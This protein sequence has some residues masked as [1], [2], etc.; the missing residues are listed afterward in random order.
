MTTK[1]TSKTA[2]VPLSMNSPAANASTGV[3][4]GSLS[5]RSRN[6]VGEI[7]HMPDIQE[8]DAV[9]LLPS[10]NPQ[11]KYEGQ[12]FC[13]G[14]HYIPGLN[15]QWKYT[16]GKEVYRYVV[17]PYMDLPFAPATSQQVEVP[18]SL[19]ELESDKKIVINRQC[20]MAYWEKHADVQYAK[21]KK[22]MLSRVKNGERNLNILPVINFAVV[23]M[24]EKEGKGEVC[25][26]THYTITLPIGEPVSDTETPKKTPRIQ[27]MEDV[28]HDGNLALDVCERMYLR[29]YGK[30]EIGATLAGM[31]TTL[32]AHTAKLE[33]RS[34]T[35]LS[36][37]KRHTYEVVLG[38]ARA[39]IEMLGE[40][41]EQKN[42]HFVSEWTTDYRAI[43]AKAVENMHEIIK[44]EEDCIMSKKWKQLFPLKKEVEVLM[45]V[46]EIK[47]PEPF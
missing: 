27:L 47:T 31:I 46:S 21:A 15:K 18:E 28:W 20:E 1:T 3:N 8:L 39:V 38:F 17:M 32:K 10:S 19:E 26:Q 36:K 12:I 16:A 6:E 45:V 4:S 14:L 11:L 44:S 23:K 25:R 41:E 5:K 34:I 7:V 37:H 9:Q 29:E 30:V 40:T 35:F 33:K 22:V 42:E 24:P 43:D 13:P 2:S